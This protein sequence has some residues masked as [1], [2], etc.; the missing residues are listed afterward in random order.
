MND[1]GNGMAKPLTDKEMSTILE[2]VYNKLNT[3]HN[4][5]SNI[6]DE[7]INYGLYERDETYYL[8]LLLYVID[9]IREVIKDITQFYSQI[10]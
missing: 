6:K 10:N 2:I 9:T 3:A 1:D 8:I 7:L 5:L 4:A